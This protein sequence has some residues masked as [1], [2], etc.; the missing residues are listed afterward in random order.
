M[1][2]LYLLTMKSNSKTF[3]CLNSLRGAFDLLVKSND[4]KAEFS[5]NIAYELDSLK[6]LHIHCIFHTPNTISLAKVSKT[7]SDLTDLH[8]HIQPCKLG[9]S[10]NVLDY[11]NKELRQP[12][13]LELTSLLAL[14]RKPLYKTIK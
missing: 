2:K 1:T 12:E 3:K 6:R 8:V 7:W 9:D 13:E 11:V 10:Q 14:Y 5:D 4:I